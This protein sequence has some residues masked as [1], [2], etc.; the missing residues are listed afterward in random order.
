MTPDTQ[1]ATRSRAPRPNSTGSEISLIRLINIVLAYRS[2]VITCAALLFVLVVV[3]TLILPRTYTV[4]SSFTPQSERLASN[5][6]GIAAQFGVPLPA[7][8]A[9]A[10]PDF[11][12]ELLKSRRILGETIATRYTFP[13]DTGEVS[14][15]LVDI[16]EIEGETKGERDEAALR[17]FR[18]MVGAELDRPSG[19]VTFEVE[20]F[21]PQLSAKIARRLL[22]LLNRFNLETRQSQAAA[23]RRFTEVR[24]AEAKEELLEVENR[25]Q[26]FLEINRDLGT[27]PLLRFR[28]ERLGAG[29]QYPAGGSE[30]SGAE[31]RAG[32]DRRSQGHPGHHDRRGARGARAAGPA[33]TAPSGNPGPGR[34]S[35]ALSQ[36]VQDRKPGE[37]ARLE[38]IRDGERRTIEVRLGE[39]PD[40]QVSL[41]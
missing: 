5:L 21:N 22:D 15:T 25:L 8:D 30:L 27:S 33:K 23:E 38:V 11:Y 19:V 12:V 37:T 41:G 24:L 7:T 14:G 16:L 26:A 10:S 29:S 28:Q 6:A 39:R 31:L 3:V 1:E 4:D 18:G 34:G 20:T 2:V 9:G 36:V 13:T 35:S 17:R 32:E 40:R